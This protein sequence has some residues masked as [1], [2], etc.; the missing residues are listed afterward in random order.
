MTPF[1]FGQRPF[2]FDCRPV[3]RGATNLHGSKGW[4]S[5]FPLMVVR[6]GQTQIEVVRP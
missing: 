2:G 3:H 6:V 1:G 5:P 4:V